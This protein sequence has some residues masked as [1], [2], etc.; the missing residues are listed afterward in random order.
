[1]RGRA[2]VRSRALCARMCA[3]TCARVRVCMCAREEERARTRACARARVCDVGYIRL[4][5]LRHTLVGG[6][7]PK[8]GDF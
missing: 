4:C 2:R 3:R 8:V 1:M 7:A 5:Y 6:V